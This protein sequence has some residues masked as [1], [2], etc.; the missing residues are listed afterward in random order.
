MSIVK[1]NLGKVILILLITVL[2]ISTIYLGY[3]NYLLE[4]KLKIIKNSFNEDVTEYKDQIDD[5][6]NDLN[7]YQSKF[8][9]EK[10]KFVNDY[11]SK[12][13]GT[14]PIEEI[15]KLDLSSYKKLMIS[16]H[17]DDE[18]FWA[19]GHLILDDYLVV[20]VTCGMD[21]NRQSEFEK[22]MNDT[23]DKYIMLQYPR[24][25]DS[26]LNREF[27]WRATSYLTQDLENIIN[28]K[29]WDVIVTHNPAGEYGHKYHKL[30]SQVVTSL[31]KDKNKLFYFGIH[32]NA[33]ELE[34]LSTETLKDDIYNKKM[35]IINRNYRS[36]N[37]SAQK[38]GH[39]FRNENFIKYSDWK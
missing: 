21:A 30:T 18:M 4:E 8:N 1:K 9:E 15:N 38:H 17:P 36:Q 26:S 31:V 13:Q 12:R 3:K 29:D 14:Y 20:C 34:K 24:S 25:V 16:T 23:G 7:L 10:Q 22:S 33:D 32:Y 5:I 37:I 19:G 6:E 28:L 11:M 2:S 39:M 27:D 35:E